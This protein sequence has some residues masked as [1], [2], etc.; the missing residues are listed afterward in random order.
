MKNITK[1]ERN[2]PW[3]DW[4]WIKP[5]R[6]SVLG[7]WMWNCLYCGRHCWRMDGKYLVVKHQLTAWCR[8]LEKLTGL[9]L[10]K[11]FSAFHGTLTFITALTRLPHPSLSWVSP[12]SPY[13]YIPPPGDVLMLSTHLRL[14]LPS[15]LF[16]SGTPQ[17]TY[18]PSSPHR[19]A[20]H[21]Q[22]I[23]FC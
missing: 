14:G 13:T 11:K 17:W 16:P 4:W 21:A 6:P 20:P 8:V 7:E 18:T 3:N 9:Q 5:C 15:G 2:L 22:P 10:V 19:N 1:L 23:S 12:I